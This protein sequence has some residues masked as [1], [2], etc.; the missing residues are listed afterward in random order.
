MGAGYGYPAV[1]GA[2]GQMRA[3]DEDR[4]RV[5]AVLNTAYVDGRLS[6]DEYDDRLES[7]LSART[8]AELDQVTAD[9]P[10]APA[11]GPAGSGVIAPATPTNG[12]AIASL[13]C[14]LAQFV[15]WPLPTIPAIVLG[16]MARRQIKR[17]GEQGAGLALAGLMLG[18]AS[19]ILG[20]LALVA[21]IAVFGIGMR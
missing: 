7:T 10:A 8:Y 14:G 6:K 4:D 12:L 17:T 19:V 5:A 16:H 3:A 1:G 13:A 2:R 18:W 21:V 15:L 20:F 9:L 11:S